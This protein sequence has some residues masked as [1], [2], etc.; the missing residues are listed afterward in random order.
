MVPAVLEN[1]AQIPK[2]NAQQ[3]MATMR[4]K[5]GMQNTTIEGTKHSSSI[6]V[7]HVIADKSNGLLKNMADRNGNKA[8]NRQTLVFPLVCFDMSSR[9]VAG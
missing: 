7:P 2:W 5:P 9:I 8:L 1:V 4:A 3:I 6:I